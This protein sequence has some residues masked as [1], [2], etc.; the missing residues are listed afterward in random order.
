ML[1]IAALINLLIYLVVLGIIVALV[2]WVVD[3]IPIPQPFNRIIKIVATVLVVLIVI[4]LLLNLA[5]IA[6][7]APPLV[8][9]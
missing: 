2:F 5:G 7:V 9:K 1:S 8:A 6:T 3:A 4:L